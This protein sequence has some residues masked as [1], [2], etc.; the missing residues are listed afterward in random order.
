MEVDNDQ[1]NSS[2]HGANVTKDAEKTLTSNASTDIGA[3][4]TSDATMTSAWNAT[5]KK[6]KSGI[7][8]ERGYESI[9][10]W[11]LYRYLL[12]NLNWHKFGLYGEN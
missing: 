2:Q 5:G 1:S 7:E 3:V 12:V 4:R 9:S 8:K 6:S 11:S 10:C